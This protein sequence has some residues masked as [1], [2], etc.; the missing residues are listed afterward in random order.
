MYDSNGKQKDG[1]QY[2]IFGGGVDLDHKKYMNIY[3][4]SRKNPRDDSIEINSL[5]RP[6][7][8]SL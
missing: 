6:V 2:P 1:L 7:Q 4:K 8:V 5:F 3:N